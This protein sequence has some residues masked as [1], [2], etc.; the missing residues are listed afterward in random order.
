MSSSYDFL[1]MGTLYWSEIQRDYDFVIT[2]YRFYK[3]PIKSSDEFST[4]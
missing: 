1:I 3:M 4:N 2:S